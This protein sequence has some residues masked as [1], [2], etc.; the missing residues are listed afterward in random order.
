MNVSCRWPNQYVL[1]GQ[2]AGPKAVELT[3]SV[4]K[5][6]P[7]NLQLVEFTHGNSITFSMTR[8]GLTRRAYDATTN[9]STIPRM[10]LAIDRSSIG[11]TAHEAGPKRPLVSNCAIRDFVVIH[12]TAD[13]LHTGQVLLCLSYHGYNFW[14]G[15]QDSNLR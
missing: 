4:R 11:N 7:S 2:P 8:S 1:G 9:N 14:C 15:R 13:L 10:P 3:S 6:F 12:R 5:S